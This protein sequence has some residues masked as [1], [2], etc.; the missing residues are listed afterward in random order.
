M[1]KSIEDDLAKQTVFVFYVS[2]MGAITFAEFE[3]WVDLI[4]SQYDNLP[5]YFFDFYGI[6]SIKDAR[7]AFYP[8]FNAPPSSGL[9]DKEA[10]ALWGIAFIRFPDRD[11]DLSSIS[12][13]TA[14]KRLE[15]YPHVVE[16]F[17]KTFPFIKLDF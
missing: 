4:V 1:D 10:E 9:G 3:M 16:R 7:N 2:T 5:T 8:R 14:L 11:K 15:E 12:R 6:E 17:K 13:K